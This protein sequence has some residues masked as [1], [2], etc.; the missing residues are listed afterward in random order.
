[1]ISD[2]ISLEKNEI[3]FVYI[4]ESWRFYRWVFALEKVMINI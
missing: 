3:I 2:N 4:G 1:V